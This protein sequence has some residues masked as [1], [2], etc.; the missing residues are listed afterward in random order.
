MCGIAGYFNPDQNYAENPK[1]NFHTLSRMINTMNHRGPDTYGHTIINSCCLAHTRLSIID[2]ENGRQPMS[3]TKD[4]NTYYIVY[5][6]EIYNYKEV[7][8]TLLRKNHTFETNSDTEVIIAAFC[9]YGPGFV[10]ELNGIFA[11]AIYDS[12]RNT[13]YLYR[14]RFGVKPLYYTKT[15]D[16][17]VFASRIDTLFEYPRVRPCIDMD[18][19]NE[20]FSLGP[21][22]TYGKGVFSGIKEIKPGE[23]LTYSPQYMTS[24]LYYRI[25]SHPHTDSYEETVE[26]TSYLLEDSIRMQ[27]VSDVPISTL[28]SGGVDS[29]YV[30]AVCSHFLP[31]DTPL[32]TY[33]FDYTD[34]A[35]Y[36]QANS[37]QPSEDRPYVDIMKGYLHS[38]HIYLTCSY[39]QLADLLEASVDSRCLP[40][41]A[42]VDSSLLYFCGEVAKHHKVTLTGE[43]A[44]EIFGGYPWFHR[45]A[46][47][48]S[49]TFPWTMDISFRKSLLHPEFAASMQMEKYIARAYR[50]TLSEVDILPEESPLDTKKRQIA[51]LN[52]RWFMQ[53]LLDR[54][55]RTSM[56]HGLEARVPFADYRVIDYV[57]NVPWSI[58][59]K[60]G[61]PKSLLRAC[62]AKYLPDTIMNR[63]KSPYPKTYHPEYEPARSR[64]RHRIAAPELSEYPCGA[65]VPRR[66]KGIWKALVRSAHGRTTDDCLPAPGRLLD[67]EIYVIIHC[68][69]KA[70]VGAFHSFLC[71]L[72]YTKYTR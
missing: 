28:L 45:D 61:V 46:M 36:F 71:V 4:G 57:F 58:K 43:C 22:K 31:E 13:L 27:M 12:M 51:Y 63:P 15:G 21:A 72:L 8:K 7:K 10:K 6:G 67:A 9:H 42:D 47:L 18:S 62:A 19:F 50:T 38:D 14:D 5:N 17:L 34:N 55:D 33:S 30:S 11:I 53:T 54:M 44:D 16:T 26:K 1:Q 59:A 65:K 40:T 3:Y 35:V 52:I 60:D 2:L 37:F 68:M 25:E 56:Q 70:E 48:Q 64:H 69:K 66:A 49:T 24:R 39:T 20:I 23:Y 41:M 32:T 29:S